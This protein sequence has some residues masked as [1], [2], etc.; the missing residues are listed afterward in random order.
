MLIT[1]WNMFVQNNDRVFVVGDF[2]FGNSQQTKEVLR[3]LTG[4]KVLIIGNHDKNHSKKWW[5]DAG[6]EEVVDEMRMKLGNH[7]VRLCHYPSGSP[8]RKTYE[9]TYIQENNETL[10]CGH[11]HDRWIMKE[12]IINVGV[13][14]WNFMPVADFQITRILEGW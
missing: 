12:Q 2:S 3:Q 1:N 6:F 5:I 10:L 8:S 14:V 11:V 4:R 9:S 7:D 13:D